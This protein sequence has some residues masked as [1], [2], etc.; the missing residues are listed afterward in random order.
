[1]EKTKRNVIL[2]HGHGGSPDHFWL[3]STKKALENRGY[4]VWAPQLPNALNPNL[5]EQLPYL[6]QHGTFTSETI[7][8]A[9]S[10]GYGEG[11]MGSEIYQQ[12]YKEFPLLLR[13][14]I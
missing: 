11:H 10:A 4:D 7:I 8:I 14:V 13:L 5:E 6:I 3:P 1:M 2:L 12:P 9:H